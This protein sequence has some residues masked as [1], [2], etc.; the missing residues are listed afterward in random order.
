MAVGILEGYD[1][2]DGGASGGGDGDGAFV[3]SEAGAGGGDGLLHSQGFSAT[4][5]YWLRSAVHF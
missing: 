4:L 5:C 2:A 1:K 3:F